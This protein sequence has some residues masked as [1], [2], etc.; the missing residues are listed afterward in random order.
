MTVTYI[1]TERGH[2]EFEVAGRRYRAFWM[3]LGHNWVLREIGMDGQTLSRQDGSAAK[4]EP[5]NWAALESF[6]AWRTKL[7]SGS[8]VGELR[9]VPQRT[10]TCRFCKAAP[11]TH[12]V[13]RMKRGWRMSKPSPKPN[14]CHV[15]AVRAARE[16]NKLDGADAPAR[17]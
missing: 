2:R 6:V 14:L 7:E 11:A 12:R 1:K 13:V 4:W 17:S 10:T 16:I 8:D 9:I 5:K 3:S 15:C